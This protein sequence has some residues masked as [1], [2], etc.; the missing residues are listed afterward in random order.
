MRVLVPLA[1]GFEEM[2][3]VILLDVLRRGGIEALAVAM[4]AAREVAGAHGLTLLA[5]TIWTEIDPAGFDMIA[6]PGG[7]GNTR[8][9]QKDERLLKMLREYHEGG[10]PLAAICAA[11]LV[12][13]SA[14]LLK[15]RTVTC[16][17]GVAEEMTDAKRLDD[18]VV[19]DG[20]IITSQ[21]PG[22]SFDFA[23]AIVRRLVGEAKAG[24][25]A[26]GM[27]L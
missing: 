21:G 27:V 8:R 23:L 24:E 14:G 15:G 3:A 11:P 22:T 1:E 12:L 4:G 2:E 16:H 13:Q 9:L 19:V 6:I 17:P 20:K 5:D 26:G 10:K 18:R 25:I 7:M